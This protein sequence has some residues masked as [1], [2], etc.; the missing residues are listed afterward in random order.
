MR[1]CADYRL[2]KSK[3]TIIVKI[4]SYF[5]CKNKNLIKRGGGV[6]PGGHTMGQARS[7]SCMNIY[8]HTHIFIFFLII[9]ETDITVQSS[10]FDIRTFILFFPQFHVHCRAYH[11]HM[12]KK[13]KVIAKHCLFILS[14]GNL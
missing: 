13:G 11:L 2:I 4:V 1:N 3:M 10:E 14:L 7:P 9:R 12:N 5:V 6:W 8:A